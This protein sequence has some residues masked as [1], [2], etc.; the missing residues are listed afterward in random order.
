[1]SWNSTYETTNINLKNEVFLAGGQERID[2]EHF[3]GKLTARERLK[4]LFDDGNFNEINMLL[5]SRVN[6]EELKK[7]HYL[8][9]GVIAAFGKINGIE[10]YAISQDC[11]ISG[12]A[13][14]EA[15]VN[16]ICET[17]EL[18][19][20]TKKPIVYLCDSGGARIEEG[21]I[22]LAAYSR[23]FRLNAE[24]SGMIPQVAAIMG[25]CAGGSSYSPAMCDFLFMVENTS[26]CFI[27]GPKVIKALTGEEITMNELGGTD[28][29]SKYSGLAHFVVKDDK[30]CLTKI[31]KLLEYIE[32]PKREY[33]FKKK[34]CYSPLG[35]QIEDVVPEDKRQPYDVIQVINRIVDDRE[36]MEVLQNF[37]P[38]MVVGFA[39]LNGNTIGIVANQANYL[40]G[41][42]DCDAADKCS[43]FIRTCD[44]FNIPL[45]VLVDVPGFFPGEKEEKKGILRHGCKMLFSF[46]EATVP[47]I[48]VIMRKAYGGAYCA[49]NSKD[50]G[51]DIVY[52]WPICEI[53]VMGAD[54]A[55]DV[56]FNKKIASADNPDK[57]R[58]EEI[59]KYE[60]KYLNPY[61]AASYG[62]VDEIIMPE[63][64]REKLISAFVALEGKTTVKYEKKHGNIAL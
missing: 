62:M 7:K 48:S 50:L 45:L 2:K 8:G 9:D 24:A 29:H 1:M 17:L 20:K 33:I 64:T 35:K 38:N 28:V 31:R 54:G 14:G 16:K 41:S 51:A 13:G 49:M 5:K 26:Q 53:A 46:A 36:F 56:M 32:I 44:C 47:K 18:A 10:T 59:E 34:I 22:S 19:I 11:T 30:Q 40:G 27:T 52:A 42:I 57:C 63:E 3:R 39:R 21:I 60:E 6:V 37:A 25:N 15:H 43:R 4:E 12:G 55:V 61:F 23:L 58:Q